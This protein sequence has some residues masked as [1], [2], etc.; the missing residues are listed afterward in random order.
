M[1]NL[2]NTPQYCLL[3]TKWKNM[4]WYSLI[5]NPDS[6]K[7]NFVL[8][9]YNGGAL[10]DHRVSYKKFSILKKKGHRSLKHQLQF[11]QIMDKGSLVW[12]EK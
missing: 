10:L 4:P 8:L 7:I 5:F 2:S 12:E 6:L 9:F 11:S 3:G 1:W